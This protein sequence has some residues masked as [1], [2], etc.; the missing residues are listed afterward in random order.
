MHK[1]DC[2]SKERPC[3]AIKNSLGKKKLNWKNKVKCNMNEWT[4]HSKV[5]LHVISRV[6]VTFPTYQ[7]AFF[8]RKLMNANAWFAVSEH[9]W[10]DFWPNDNTEIGPCHEK[11]AIKQADTLSVRQRKV[12]V[13]NTQWTSFP[14][15]GV[16]TRES[17]DKYL[18][19]MFL[20]HGIMGQNLWRLYALYRISDDVASPWNSMA[21]FNSATITSCHLIF[22]PKIY[23]C[24]QLQS[25][26][27]KI[28]FSLKWTGRFRI[29]PGIFFQWN[30]ANFMWI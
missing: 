25:G 13:Q 29:C 17:V 20:T 12:P 10:G 18:I 5:V 28:Y 4:K 1:K 2:Y 24:C 26:C 9:W 16:S 23:V 19:F 30:F 7:L 11:R 6:L 14:I 15:Y 8:Y 27:F 21:V 22:L 3:E